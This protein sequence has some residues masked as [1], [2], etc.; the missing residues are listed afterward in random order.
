MVKK[1][2]TSKQHLKTEHSPTLNTILMV[3]RTLEKIGE[4]IVTVA[5]LK[6]KLPKQVNHNTLMNILDYLERSCKIYV[7]IKG[8]TWL[9]N[10]NQKLQ[11]AIK[12]GRRL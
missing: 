3:E 9:V 10:D 1:K 4:C 12:E 8:I 5:Q 11:N 6:K 2:K 7:S